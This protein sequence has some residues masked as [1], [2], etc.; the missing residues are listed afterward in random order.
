MD[1]RSLMGP[2]TTLCCPRRSRRAL[3]AFALAFAFAFVACS[4][5][6]A[7][8]PSAGAPSEFEFSVWGFTRGSTKVQLRGDTLLV[9]RIPFAGP[10]A[11]TDTGRTVPTDAAWRAFW[12]AT[13]RAGVHR[14]RPRY[15]ME[16]ASDGGGWDTRIVAGG[17][18][19]TSSGDNAFPD[20]L[21]REH[22]LDMTADFQVFLTA[23]NDLVGQRVGN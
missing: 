4:T 13:A 8:F 17:R 14:W 15:V 21:G 10:G 19:V 18:I 16:I 12:A 11:P 1:H 23:V 3:T 2:V 22:E 20:H 7:P 9:W 6:P 5:A